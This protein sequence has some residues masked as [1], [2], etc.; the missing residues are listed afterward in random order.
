MQDSDLS[1]EVS[2]DDEKHQQSTGKM[3]LCII[4]LRIISLLF[5]N[6]VSF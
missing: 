1:T 2:V 3:I 6:T 5:V 4:T